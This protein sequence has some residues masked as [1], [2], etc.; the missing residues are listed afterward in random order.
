MTR[1]DLLNYCL[2]PA[3]T[4]HRRTH[5]RDGQPG[6]T[7]Q[8]S[9]G[10]DCQP[11]WDQLIQSI[12]WLKFGR[13]TSLVDGKENRPKKEIF[14]F[15]WLALALPCS[16]FFFLFEDGY[17]DPCASVALFL[18]RSL[19]NTPYRT[20]ELRFVFYLCFFFILL[21][22]FIFLFSTSKRAHNV[23]FFLA[24]IH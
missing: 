14:L 18:P 8:R 20:D 12:L 11:V 19:L 15:L 6:R 13:L 21:K 17:S 16:L 5:P 1:V 24:K 23:G 4:E 22:L 7:H 3:C 10:N 9:E 2:V